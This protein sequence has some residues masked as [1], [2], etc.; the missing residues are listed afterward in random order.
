MWTAPVRIDIGAGWP[1]SDPFR[2]EW[3]G[4]VLN[5]A[6]NKRGVANCEGQLI[7]NPKGIPSRSGLGASGCL[8]ALELVAKNPKLLNDKFELIR[9]VHRFENEIVGNRAGFQDQAAAIFGGMNLWYFGPDPFSQGKEIIE[10][11][12][13]DGDYLEDRIV[14]VYLGEHYSKDVHEAVFSN[15]KRNVPRLRRLSGLN[16]RMYHL[17]LE[18]K[19]IG[20]EIA[21]TWEYQKALSPIIETD[22]MREL[23]K[24]AEGKYDACRAQGAGAGGSM[25][26]YTKNKRRL[27]RILSRKVEVIDFKFD[28]EGLSEVH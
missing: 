12:S 15:Y 22:Q 24:Y 16:K 14:L 4:E 9:K 1:D 23:Q 11:K 5:V 3:G 8:S 27:E 17:I 6:I 13:L 2:R 28:S 26:F 7:V 10:R 18:K 21:E 25:M 20:L 19:D